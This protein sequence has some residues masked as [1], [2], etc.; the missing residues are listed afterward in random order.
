MA[1]SVCGERGSGREANERRGRAPE[2]V[3]GFIWPGW[4][5]CRVH[6]DGDD[7]ARGAVFLERHHELSLALGLATSGMH[8]FGRGTVGFSSGARE[9]VRGAASLV[10]YSAGRGVCCVG[11]TMPCMCMCG[12]GRAVVCARG[13][14]HAGL[15]VL[16]RRRAHAERGR[17]VA[18]ERFGRQGSIG[19]AW[20]W[21]VGPSG[22][23]VDGGVA[24]KLRGNGQCAG[25]AGE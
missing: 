14:A 21:C 1:A 22:A 20:R 17:D 25:H 11:C 6:L 23:V 5:R 15:G 24:L 8:F 7:W 2:G 10:G 12:A 4:S 19:F 9:T 3:R 16:G 13:N 18:Y